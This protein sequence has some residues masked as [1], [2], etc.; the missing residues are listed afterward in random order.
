MYVTELTLHPYIVSGELH[1]A[2]ITSKYGT[3][4]QN[5]FFLAACD[6]IND[7]LW[8]EKV[9]YN[10][11]GGCGCGCSTRTLCFHGSVGVSTM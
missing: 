2:A 3:N 4:M 9:G 8:D 6:I 1:I 5:G 11:T 10:F 7:G